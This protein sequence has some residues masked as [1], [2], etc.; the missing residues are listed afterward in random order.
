M[1]DTDR[2]WMRGLDARPLFPGLTE[3]WLAGVL[4]ASRNE[5]DDDDDPPPCPAVNGPFPRLPPLGAEG[6]L[7]AA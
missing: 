6:E 4:R 1:K 5:D 7:L 3:N 2:T